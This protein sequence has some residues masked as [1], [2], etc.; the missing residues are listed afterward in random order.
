MRNAGL[1]LAAVLIATTAV[2]QPPISFTTPV[3]I[4]K[5]TSDGPSDLAIVGGHK[6]SVGEALQLKLVGLPDVDAKLP[7]GDQLKWIRHVIMV[8]KGPLDVADSN[9]TLDTSVAITI[10]PTFSWKLLIAF[11]SEKPG[12][13]D[14]VVTWPEPP[15]AGQEACIVGQAIHRIDV[16]DPTPPPPP[17]DATPTIQSL[18]V[19]PNSGPSG[20]NGV[21][22]GV[23]IPATSVVTM[24][25]CSGQTFPATFS[26]AQSFTSSGPITIRATNGGKTVTQSVQVTVTTPPTPIPLAGMFVEIIHDP[27]KSLP[28]GQADILASPDVRKWADANCTKDKAGKV[29]FR[30]FAPSED[31]NREVDPA[32]S[33]G[34]KQDTKGITDP[35]W[36][37][38]NPQGLWVIESLPANPAAAVARL[39]E[40]KGAK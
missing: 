37:L 25:C 1:F 22:S 29:A 19:T 26:H 27:N 2:G 23:V 12:A 33:A 13:Y 35:Y 7:L 4:A 39:N 11:T 32:W 20:F 21:I 17:P 36:L 10:T 31:L 6:T 24:D 8:V 30:Y 38:S 14:L 9:V 28:Q 15:P 18:S 5:R 34:Q 3:E 16:K 40:F